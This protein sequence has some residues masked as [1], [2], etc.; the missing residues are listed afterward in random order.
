MP[1]KGLCR[2]HGF[3]DAASSAWRL[4]FDN[5]QVGQQVGCFIAALDDRQRSR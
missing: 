5:H 2:E 1:I 4:R 3:S